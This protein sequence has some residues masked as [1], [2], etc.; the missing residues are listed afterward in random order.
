MGYIPTEWQTGDIITAEKLNKAEEGIA[1]AG[2]FVV[3]ATGYD[4]ETGDPILSATWQEV[5]DALSAGKYVVFL[6]AQDDSCTHWIFYNCGNAQPSEPY[7]AYASTSG[8]S[9]ILKFVAIGG[10]ASGILKGSSEP[11]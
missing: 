9:T 1:A 5:H 8:E 4:E 6:N 3:T 10:V 7:Y 11:A 2:A